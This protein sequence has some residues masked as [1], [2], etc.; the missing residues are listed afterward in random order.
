MINEKQHANVRFVERHFGKIGTK[1]LV[2]KKL[3]PRVNGVNEQTEE[4]TPKKNL[5]L[6]LAFGMR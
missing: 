5:F 3:V 1:K 6:V 2:K 4:N